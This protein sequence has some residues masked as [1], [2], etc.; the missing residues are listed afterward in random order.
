[1]LIRLSRAALRE[2]LGVTAEPHYSHVTRWEN[3]LPRSSFGHRERTARILEEAKKHDGLI[4]AGASYVGAGVTDCIQSG[5]D[6]AATA[7][8]RQPVA[9]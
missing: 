4:L 2:V 9:A 8:A 1:E 3:G 5:M 6:A 7:L